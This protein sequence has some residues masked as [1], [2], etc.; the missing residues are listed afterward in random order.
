MDYE[1]I[2]WAVLAAIELIITI[3]IF[4]PWNPGYDPKGDDPYRYCPKEEDEL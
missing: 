2:F 1:L 4:L 3:I